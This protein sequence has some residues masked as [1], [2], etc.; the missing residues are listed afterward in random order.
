LWHHQYPL[1]LDGHHKKI[2]AAIVINIY[3]RSTM[4]KSVNRSDVSVPDEFSSKVL[5][6]PGKGKPTKP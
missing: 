2:L 4:R 3:D 1:I 6:N 5:G